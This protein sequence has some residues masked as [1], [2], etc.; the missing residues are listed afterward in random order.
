MLSKINMESYINKI[1]L[2]LP[3]FLSNNENIQT[4]SI[5]SSPDYDIDED[6]VLEIQPKKENTDNSSSSDFFSSL[7]SWIDS[8]F[9]SGSSWGSSSSSSSGS[10]SN[11]GSGSSTSSSSPTKY[12]NG[13]LIFAN[14]KK[15]TVSQSNATVTTN[16]DGSAVVKYSEE[17]KNYTNTYNKDGLVSSKSVEDDNTVKTDT[18]VYNSN[19]KVIKS[20]ETTKYKDDESYETIEKQFDDAG[21]QTATIYESYNKDKE[22]LF[23]LENKGIES[24]IKYTLNKEDDEVVKSGIITF[25]NGTTLTVKEGQSVKIASDGSVTITNKKPEDTK[26]TSII[27]T[28]DK[29]GQ[30]I[31]CLKTLKDGGTISQRKKYDAAGQ[32]ISDSTTDENGKTT[33]ITTSYD[34]DG[35]PVQTTSVQQDNKTI[36]KYTETDKKGNTVEIIETTENGKITREETILDKK[37]DNRPKQKVITNPDG[38]TKTIKYEYNKNGTIK[39]ETSKYKTADNKTVTEKLTYSYDKKGNIEKVIVKQGKKKTTFNYTNTYDSEGNLLSQTLKND[40]NGATKTI[41]YDNEKLDDDGN[42]TKTIT[43]NPVITNNKVIFATG[44]IVDITGASDYDI[45]DDGSVTVTYEDG[46]KKT[47]KSKLN[48]YGHI[49]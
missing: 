24:G 44:E 48:T 15:V 10:G 23:K 33:T 41:T 4:E 20:Q 39:T 7:I 5:N 49:D 46:V 16:T 19:N 45:N 42:P 32:V 28:Y 34:A 11:S 29:K 13:E 31:S 27:T 37:H 25:T 47:Y 14:G 2:Y 38:S 1:K 12:T 40:K 35:N 30:E 6:S 3:N 8:S 43:E 22:L 18:Y 9:F 17:G 21:K 26:Y 36:N